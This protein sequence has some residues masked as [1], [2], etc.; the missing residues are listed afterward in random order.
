MALHI[1]L[2]VG[3]WGPHYVI[4]AGDA[5][6]EIIKTNYLC[7]LLYGSVNLSL[8]SATV[9]SIKG[10]LDVYKYSTCKLASVK[11]RF[12]MLHKVKLMRLKIG[13]Y[14]FNKVVGAC[15]VSK[16]K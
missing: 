8:A 9:N 14:I 16:P 2:E 15:V 1:S 12:Y 4:Q 3:E 5:E 11:I 7:C 13:F 6:Q 10:F